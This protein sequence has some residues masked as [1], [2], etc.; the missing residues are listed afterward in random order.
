[1]S[2]YISPLCPRWLIMTQRSPRRP[3]SEW[4]GPWE[5][6][7]PLCNLCTR[8]RHFITCFLQKPAPPFFR[9][10]FVAFFD[11]ALVERGKCRQAVDHF[12]I[13]ARCESFASQRGT[14]V[15]LPVFQ[16][17]CSPPVTCTFVSYLSLFMSMSTQFS[18]SVSPCVCL[19]YYVINPWWMWRH[20]HT[21]RGR[22]SSAELRIKM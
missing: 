1:M 2:L 12:S 3:S 13:S 21:Y 11:Y 8:A 22:E 5:F 19:S 14:K 15:L 4:N 7:K 16:S 18:L 17:C 20:T 9:L 6:V 10:S